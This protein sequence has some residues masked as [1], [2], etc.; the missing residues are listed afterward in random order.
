MYIWWSKDLAK[1]SNIVGQ[2]FETNLSSK[3]FDRL[4]TLQ[5]IA[6]AVSFA[7]VKKKN[8]LNFFKNIAKQS[9]SIKQFLWRDQTIK[10]SS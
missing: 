1:R 4:A 7:C 3:M 8:F 10:H 2:T 5:N 9:L 6:Y